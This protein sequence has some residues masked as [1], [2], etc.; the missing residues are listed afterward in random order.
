MKAHMFARLVNAWTDAITHLV[1]SNLD[2]SSGLFYVAFPPRQLILAWQHI[3]VTYNTM[4]SSDLPLLSRSIW[5]KSKSDSLTNI[6]SESTKT[7]HQF[8]NS[9]HQH[10]SDEPI[11]LIYVSHNLGTRFGVVFVEI[12]LQQWDFC[13]LN[14]YSWK[15]RIIMLWHTY[16]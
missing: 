15:S 4:T 3:Y 12:P 5:T 6:I 2:G 1:L 7:F 8:S 9:H 16:G 14:A 10:Q 13:I 11:L